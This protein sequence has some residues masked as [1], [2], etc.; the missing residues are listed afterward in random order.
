MFRSKARPHVYFLFQR[1]LRKSSISLR[2][3]SL[4]GL[5][6]SN[7]HEHTSPGPSNSSSLPATRAIT[8]AISSLLTRLDRP[9]PAFSVS[10]SR[11]VL[12][13]ESRS[14]A[15]EIAVKCSPNCETEIPYSSAS[16]LCVKCGPYFVTEYSRAA[17][18]MAGFLPRG[19]TFEQ[20]Q[21]QTSRA[22]RDFYF[23]YPWSSSIPLT[24]PATIS[25]I[26]RS[27]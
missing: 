26:G 5:I 17:A 6:L 25:S 20:K 23:E 13:I 2:S 9:D 4:M 11:S 27:F 3:A 22:C 19:V 12:T 18:H 10:T 15:S 24:I 7:T 8:S 16:C 21:F 14:T 1:K